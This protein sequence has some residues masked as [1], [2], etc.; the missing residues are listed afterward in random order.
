MRYHDTAHC[1]KR[2]IQIPQTQTVVAKRIFEL[3]FVSNKIIIKLHLQNKAQ[4]D[5]LRVK[6]KKPC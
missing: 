2:G 4:V 5:A 3:H 6:V 1:A